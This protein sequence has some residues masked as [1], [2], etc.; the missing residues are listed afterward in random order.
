M[1]SHPPSS[2][3]STPSDLSGPPPKDLYPTSDIRFVITEV[4]KLQAQQEFILRDLHESRGDIRDVRDRLA[5]LEERVE[6]L[7][8]KGFIVA[9][10]T[11]A[12]V[13]VGGLLTLAPKL[14][15][16]IGTGTPG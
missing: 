16:W 13:I 14:Q 6:H 11:T 2:Q 10:V 12:L 7:P 5:R 15:E 1:A 4:T 8:S 3:G 9:V